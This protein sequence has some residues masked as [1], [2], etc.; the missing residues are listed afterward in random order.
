MGNIGIGDGG[1]GRLG[2]VPDTWL[3]RECGMVDWNSGGEIS[4]ESSIGIFERWEM[5]N[6]WATLGDCTYVRPVGV[7]TLLVAARWRN[8]RT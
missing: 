7:S 3:E 6:G 8:C 1:G 5:V 2:D 4:R